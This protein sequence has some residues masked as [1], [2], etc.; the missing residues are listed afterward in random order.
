MSEKEL[1]IEPQGE[2]DV[3]YSESKVSATRRRSSAVTPEVLQGELFDH[4][5][6][7]TQRGLKSR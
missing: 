3:G 5:Y 1:P 7:T 6:E 4:R 2:K